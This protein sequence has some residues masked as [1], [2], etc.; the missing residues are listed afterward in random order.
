MQR[1][2]FDFA[3]KDAYIRDTS[4]REL[5]DLAAAH[6]HA[7]LLINKMVSLDDMEW[8]GWSIRVIDE[9]N[10][11]VLSI[12]IPDVPYFPLY[13]PKTNRLNQSV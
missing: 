7:M 8:R 11:S 4:G 12:L 13:T 9:A 6:R 2:F 3:S 1:F 10:Q 5:S